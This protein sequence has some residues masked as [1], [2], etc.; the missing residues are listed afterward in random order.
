MSANCQS[1]GVRAWSEN[2]HGRPTSGH[3]SGSGDGGDDLAGDE[4]GLE[5]VD[6]WDAVVA[7]THVGQAG[8][9]V[10]VEVGVIVLLKSD[11][12]QL[13]AWWQRP[14]RILQSRH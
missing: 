14:L 11:R 9:Q 2:S 10:H 12:A 5:L 6:L 1:I 3:G 7:R 13:E 4:L 8:D